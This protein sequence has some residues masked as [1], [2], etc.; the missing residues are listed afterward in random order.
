VSMMAV[1]LLDGGLQ[2]RAAVAKCRA[3]R[4]FRLLHA[5]RLSDPDSQVVVGL[6]LVL[7]PMMLARVAESWWPSALLVQVAL[8]WPTL[9]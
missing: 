4:A 2:Y 9:T 8:L 1:V 5:T 7:P 6:P 3:C